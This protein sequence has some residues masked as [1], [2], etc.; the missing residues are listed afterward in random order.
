MLQRFKMYF[1]TVGGYRIMYF[2]GHNNFISKEPLKEL[3]VNQIRFYEAVNALKVS[4]NCQKVFLRVLLISLNEI[5]ELDWWCTHK[6][7]C[8]I[9]THV[10]HKLY[11]FRFTHSSFY[12]T[13]FLFNDLKMRTFL[14]IKKS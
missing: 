4:I 7:V 8:S 6:F 2:L 12:I 5:S 10:V 3:F 14:L 11:Y 13:F 9:K 1:F